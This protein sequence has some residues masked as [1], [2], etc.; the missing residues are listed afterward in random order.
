MKKV[1]LFPILLTIVLVSCK[2]PRRPD[3]NDA[4]GRYTSLDDSSQ[5]VIEPNGRQRGGRYRFIGTSDTFAGY[6]TLVMPDK[7]GESGCIVY[8]E[9]QSEISLDGYGRKILEF[10]DD[11]VIMR[12]LGS[13]NI[14][15]K[16]QSE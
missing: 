9:G 4:V 16:K 8:G 7:N 11:A 12:N 3:I 14:N 6:W 15:F 13:R 5:L 10:D 1:H 2:D